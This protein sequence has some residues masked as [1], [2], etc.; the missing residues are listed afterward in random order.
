MARLVLGLFSHVE[1]QRLVAC[2][3][4]FE[5]VRR[6]QLDLA[7]RLGQKVFQGHSHAL[8]LAKP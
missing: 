3:L 6:D 4:R 2:L 7:F 8:I 5:L 1:Q